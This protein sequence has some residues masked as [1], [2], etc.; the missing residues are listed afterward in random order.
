MRLLKLCCTNDKNKL[1]QFAK[2][3]FV[4][5]VI[6]NEKNKITQQWRRVVFLLG[7]AEK[8]NE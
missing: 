4:V 7:V 6:I 8:K 2:Y 1:G 3:F 5:Y